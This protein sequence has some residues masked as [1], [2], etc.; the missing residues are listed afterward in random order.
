MFFFTPKKQNMQQITSAQFKLGLKFGY[1]RTT[2][3]NKFYWLL[4][5]WGSPLLS[6]AEKNAFQNSRS[7]MRCNAEAQVDYKN[8]FC[9]A[10]KEKTTLEDKA[11]LKSEKEKVE[12]EAQE[13][14]QELLEEEKRLHESTLPKTWDEAVEKQKQEK[15]KEEQRKLRLKKQ[16]EKDCEKKET[17]RIQLMKNKKQGNTIEQ[18][19]KKNDNE[20]KE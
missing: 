1:I 8:P 2:I 19:F 3:N 6:D 15:I 20:K 14:R 7:C 18:L 17:I 16:R 9:A 5:D 12:R 11:R 4:L 10:C 13:R